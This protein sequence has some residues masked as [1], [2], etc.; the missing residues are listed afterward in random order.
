MNKSFRPLFK[1]E[2]FQYLVCNC[3]SQISLLHHLFVFFTVFHFAPILTFVH[4]SWLIFLLLTSFLWYLKMGKKKTLSEVLRAQIVALHEQNLSERQISPEMGCNKSAVHQ[5]IAK[6]QE[7]GYY[8]YQK[9]TGRP[10][11]TTARENNLM[12]RSVMRSQ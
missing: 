2:D 9:R 4:I 12:R 3:I 10:R 6:Y 1:N 8:T 11:I 5:A 7:Y